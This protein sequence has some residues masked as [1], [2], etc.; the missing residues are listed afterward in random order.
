[1]GLSQLRC[2]A[3]RKREKGEREER[4][5]ELEDLAWISAIGNELRPVR[6]PVN[7]VM[8]GRE[9]EREEREEGKGLR[10]LSNSRSKK[11]RQGWESEGMGKGIM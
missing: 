9:R 3:Q 4:Q 8:R 7:R 5:E 1:M 2:C 11:V 6:W 10:R